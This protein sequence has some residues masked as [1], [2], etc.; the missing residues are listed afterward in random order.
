MAIATLNSMLPYEKGVYNLSDVSN[1]AENCRVYRERKAAVTDLTKEV[2]KA[3]VV[4][5]RL[6]L[7]EVHLPLLRLPVSDLL[8]EASDPV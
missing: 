6:V 5:Q 3:G 1:A 8:G 7:V 4:D 2:Q